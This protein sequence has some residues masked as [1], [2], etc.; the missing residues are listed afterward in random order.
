MTCGPCDDAALYPAL[1]ATGGALKEGWGALGALRAPWSWPCPPP[2]LLC[3]SSPDLT[4][5]FSF[6]G[7]NGFF[8]GVFLC[9]FCF[10]GNLSGFL[11][12]FLFCLGCS[13][14]LLFSTDFLGGG[15]LKWTLGLFGLLGGRCGLRLCP[16]G[17]FGFPGSRSRL[18]SSSM[19]RALCSFGSSA[20]STSSLTWS[21][22]TSFADSSDPFLSGVGIAVTKEAR[23]KRRRNFMA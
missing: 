11:A 21:E 6:C 4:C 10:C 7:G 5:F 14:G 1:A 23:R 2:S 17:R 15:L 3:L 20:T 12:T 8:G 16:S 22:V 18:S 19:G 13:F 9:L